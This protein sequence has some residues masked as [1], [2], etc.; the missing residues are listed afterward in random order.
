MKKKWWHNSVVYQIYPK[1]FCDSNNDGIGDL[2][3]IISKLDYLK[4][5][6]ID[7]IWLSPV[8][9][10]PNDDNGYDISDYY[11]IMDEFGTMEDMDRLLK[12]ANNRNIKILMDLVVNHTS[13]EHKWFKEAIKNKDSK[14]RDYY[15]FRKPLDGDV[16]NGLESCFGGSAWEMDETSNEY[17]LHLFSKKQPDLNWENPNMRKEIYN[18]MN[19][20]INKGIVGFRMD[21]IDLIGKDIDK[22]I[23]ANGPK[24]H[25]LIKEMNRE[26]FGDKNLLTVGETW[27]VTPDIAKLYSNPNG[28]ELSMVFQF[29]HIGLDEIKGKSKW[30]LANLD[31]V[32]LKKVFSK[33]QAELEGCGWNSLFWN[34]HDL[35]RI[36]S[37]WGND[38]GEY[39]KL[40]AKML[41]TILHMQKGTPYIYQ[42]EEIGM[43]NVKFDSIEDYKDIETLNMYK[44]RIDKGYD[45]NDIMNSIYVKSRDNARTPM[46]WSKEQNGGFTKGIPWIR[47]NENYKDINVDEALRDKDSVFYHYKALINLRKENDV[48]IY[49]TYNCIDIN[50]KAIYSYVRELNGIKFLVV[51]NFYDKIEKFILPQNIH[52]DKCQLILSNYKDSNNIP[53][54]IVLRPYEALIYKLI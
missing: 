44:E 4:N 25:T 48:I 13:S 31:F 39:R 40:S 29:E 6:G 34:N 16:P 5:L 37:R 46:Q 28:D 36:V 51:A 20:W 41:A 3:G 49:G 30:D 35:P 32:E 19:F 14:Y 2:N 54:E 47:V 10:S 11:D 8:Y 22:E 12:E 9:K 7:V 24:L 52:Y 18:M 21:V 33:W 38:K 27:G 43:T 15:I 42:G 26:T 1:S 17:Y 45:R 23:T 53:N 50:H